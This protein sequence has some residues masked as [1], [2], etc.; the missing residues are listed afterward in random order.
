[1]S[2]E[3][4]E[5]ILD[6][7]LETFSSKGATQAR[8]EDVA[9]AAGI[10]KG[11]VY[12]HFESKDDIV[13]SLLERFL[14]AELEEIVRLATG[15][16]VAHSIIEWTASL[17]ER[18]LELRKYTSLNHEFYSLALRDEAIQ[19]RFT[20]YYRRFRLALEDAIDQGTVNG[21]FES[22]DSAEVATMIMTICEGMTTLVGFDVEGVRA[23]SKRAIEIVLST[24]Q[25]NV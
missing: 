5:Q 24:I 13:Q 20:G 3:R 15:E 16:S 19:E 4:R 21:E 23:A 18:T 17:A 25:S 8:V 6:A 22:V 12:L 7:A 14:D 10:A 11:T 1:M 2:A 9:A